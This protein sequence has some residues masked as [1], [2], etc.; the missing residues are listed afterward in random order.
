MTDW[1]GDIDKMARARRL[2]ERNG[3]EGL[4]PFVPP[5]SPADPERLASE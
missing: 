2:V 3:R 5:P 4:A 1:T